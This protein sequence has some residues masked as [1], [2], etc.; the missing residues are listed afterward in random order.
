MNLSFFLLFVLLRP[1][2]HNSVM[3]VSFVFPFV[4]EPSKTFMTSLGD[5]CLILLEKNRN[6]SLTRLFFIFIQKEILSLFF[7]LLVYMPFAQAV[8]NV[9]NF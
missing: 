6:F 7:F 2:H 3:I 9:Q 1:H 5:G 4:F 8:V